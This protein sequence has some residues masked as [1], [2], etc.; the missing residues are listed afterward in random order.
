MAA[1]K[2]KAHST[3]ATVARA[4][5]LSDEALGQVARIAVEGIRCGLEASSHVEAA[6]RD[7]RSALRQLVL[8]ERELRSRPQLGAQLDEQ[9]RR[10]TGVVP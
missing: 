3:A 4:I 9:P 10:I 1:G 6:E 7:L 8:A 5:E 2:Q